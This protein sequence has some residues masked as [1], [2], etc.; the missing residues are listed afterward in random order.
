MLKQHLQDGGGC[1]LATH[2]A[3]RPAGR[4]TQDLYLVSGAS[5]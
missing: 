3:H 2:G 1:I 4:D 5:A